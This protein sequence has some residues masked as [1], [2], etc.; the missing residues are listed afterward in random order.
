MLLLLSL[1]RRQNNSSN[2]IRVRIFL[3][4]SYSF[5]I[6]TFIYSIVLSK[7]Y[8]IT[9]QNEES[10]YPFADQ[11]RAKTLPDLPDEAEH[12]YIADISEYP[13]AFP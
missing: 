3:S 12:T 1:E 5:G 9:D 6:E 13:Q 11:N 4:V 2:P 10:V 7:T 8:P